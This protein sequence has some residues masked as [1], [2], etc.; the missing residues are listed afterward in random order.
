[1]SAGWQAASAGAV[2]GLFAEFLIGFLPG[3]RQQLAVLFQPAKKPGHNPV[4]VAAV[5]Q[6]AILKKW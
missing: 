6:A 5:L 3:D 2:G 1:V 4:E